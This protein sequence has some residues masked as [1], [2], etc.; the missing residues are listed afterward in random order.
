MNNFDE[1]DLLKDFNMGVPDSS[2]P[3]IPLFEVKNDDVFVS[4]VLVNIDEH[5]LLWLSNFYNYSNIKGKARCTLYFMLKQMIEIKHKKVGDEDYI[6]ENTLIHIPDIMPNSEKNA[7]MYGKMGFNIVLSR[8]NY[9]DKKPYQTIGNLIEILESQCNINIDE[10][11]PKK[12]CRSGSTSRVESK[13]KYKKIKKKTNKKK[14]I[15]KKK[16]TNE[17][18]KIN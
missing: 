2:E 13:G 14:K 6:N 7:K 18:K 10:P 16:K 17:K 5:N 11:N 15:N 4:L 12:Q 3:D 8:N 9:I 1:E